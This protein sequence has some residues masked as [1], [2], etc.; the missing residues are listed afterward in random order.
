MNELV[1]QPRTIVDSIRIAFKA[2]LRTYNVL[3]QEML[4]R[5]ILWNTPLLPAT[6]FLRTVPVSTTLAV[7]GRG[8]DIFRPPVERIFTAFAEATCGSGEIYLKISDSRKLYLR[9]KLTCPE[10]VSRLYR[11]SSIG[12]SKCPDP[13]GLE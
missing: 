10:S 1:S 4:N 7:M 6:G 9:R 5:P 3:V 11:T 8:P 12:S 2:L 13:N